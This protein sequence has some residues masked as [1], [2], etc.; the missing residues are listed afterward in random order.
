MQDGRV[1][2]SIPE[3]PQ[4]S[5]A[6]RSCHWFPIPQVLS[7]WTQFAVLEFLSVFGDFWNVQNSS[8]KYQCVYPQKTW[9]PPK[10]TAL[11]SCSSLIALSM[12]VHMLLWPKSVSPRIAVFFQVIQ[13]KLPLLC[14]K[15][16]QLWKCH[17][18]LFSIYSKYS[19]LS[20]HQINW[21]LCL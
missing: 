8:R 17:F 1:W 20:S 11:L 15:A 6:V 14:W 16:L 19:Q 5:V 4:S 2:A 10:R 12:L 21:M 3:S 9:A 7:S 18:W 13:L